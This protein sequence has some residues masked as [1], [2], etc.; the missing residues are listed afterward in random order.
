MGSHQKPQASHRQRRSHRCQLHMQP[1]P[2]R[3]SGSACTR[4]ASCECRL[5]RVGHI[6]TQRSKDKHSSA[7]KIGRNNKWPMP[8]N[9]WTS[10]TP[11]LSKQGVVGGSDGAHPNNETQELG[12]ATM[13]KHLHI[14]EHE[15][16]PVPTP[17][18]MPFPSTGGTS[19]RSGCWRLCLRS[20]AA[21]VRKEIVEQG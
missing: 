20:S 9:R 5:R 17:Q 21:Q 8:A 10:N 15:P 6:H 13:V 11:S 19:N 3:W 4:E 14:H 2:R 12:C 18:H 7:R 16:A 1:L